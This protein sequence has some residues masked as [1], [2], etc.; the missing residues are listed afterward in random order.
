[1]CA[2]MLCAAERLRAAHRRPAP[3]KQ[4]SGAEMSVLANSL[5][6]VQ[7]PAHG[8]VGM[9]GPGNG[10]KRQR[11]LSQVLAASRMEEER[12]ACCAFGCL[13]VPALCSECSLGFCGKKRERRLSQ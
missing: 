13:V 6:A 9:A 10:G 1:M 5:A 12:G 3:E 4:L 8:G 7:Q 2:P 11:G